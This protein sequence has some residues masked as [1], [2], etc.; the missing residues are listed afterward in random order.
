MRPSP[1]GLCVVGPGAIAA[2]HAKA[3][4]ALGDLRFEW[5]VGREESSAAAFAREWGFAQHT[6]DLE[7]SLTDSDVDVVLIA[8]P[9]ELHFEQAS[10]ALEAGKHVIVEIPAAMSFDEALDL[11]RL[12]KR[13]GRRLLVCHTMRSYP[14]IREVRRRV[15]SGT[16]TVS[17]VTGFF[18]VPRRAN[19]NWAGGT[20]S[21]VD[22]LLWHHA[23]HQVDA[24]MWTLGIKH[25]DRVRAQ[26]GKSHPQ[27]GMTMD[28]SVS[29]RTPELQVVT[30]TLTYNT[31]REIWLTRFV[32]DEELLIYQDGSLLDDQGQ[33]LVPAMDWS[34]LRPQD[35]DML[36]AIRGEA[37]S[38]FSIESVLPA[39]RA[40][41]DAELEGS[42]AC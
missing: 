38:E 13:V 30:H 5:V 18:A 37:E 24:A 36:A 20:R 3:L 28:L 31:A 41:Q 11:E 4:H 15:Q 34:D 14:A 26:F 23:C 22:N 25:A 1:L 16:L 19:E 32:A 10:R 8:S 7:P 39:M 27:F 21:W 42:A 12:S 2:A 9:N 6:V 40:L 17:Q 33:E 35:Q 29:F